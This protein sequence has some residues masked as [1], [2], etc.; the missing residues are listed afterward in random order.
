MAGLPP[1]GSHPL[2]M[3]N[4]GNPPP[5]PPPPPAPGPPAGNPIGTTPTGQKWVDT[6]KYTTQN[7]PWNSTLSGI[8][9]HE[10]TSVSTLLSLNHGNSTVVDRNTIRYPGRV[11]VK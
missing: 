1:E 5:A 8:A 6:A 3:V 4:T 9:S 2:R 11:R 10:H 7:P